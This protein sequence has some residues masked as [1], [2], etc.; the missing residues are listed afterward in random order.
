MDDE[1]WGSTGPPPPDS[2]TPP[3]SVGGAADTVTRSSLA[4]EGPSELV[5]SPEVAPQASPLTDAAPRRSPLVLSLAVAGLVGVLAGAVWWVQG[6]ASSD[7]IQAA[8][9]SSPNGP[10]PALT[11]TPSVDALSASPRPTPTV[12]PSA[13]PATAASPP[14]VPSAVPAQPAPIV[15]P[16]T[17]ARTPVVKPT[18]TVTPKPTPTTPKPAP[19]TPKPTPTPPPP[20]PPAGSVAV[21]KAG[22]AVGLPGCSSPYCRYV[23][24]TLSGFTTSPTCTFI[25]PQGAFGSQVFPVNFSGQTRFYYG[26]P[27]SS[28]IVQCAGVSGSIVW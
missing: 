9:A 14:G 7:G 27:G 3:A 10:A 1:I 16:T 21:F 15:R 28:L 2:A 6:R 12:I 22:S 20:P 5:A 24:L 26:Y 17:P 11:M 4:A 8:G 23:G 25:A 18:V 13:S 19:T